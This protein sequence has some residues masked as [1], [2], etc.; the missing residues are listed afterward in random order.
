MKY[1]LFIFAIIFSFNCV[2]VAKADSEIVLLAPLQEQEPPCGCQAR[3]L[4]AQNFS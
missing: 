3:A 4:E 2:N 1:I